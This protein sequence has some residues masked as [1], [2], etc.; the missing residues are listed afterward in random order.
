MVGENSTVLII[1]NDQHTRELYQ[2]FLKRYYR[3]IS[4]ADESEALEAV[5]NQSVST[6]ILEPAS[7]NNQGWTL[8][9]KLRSLPQTNEVP[10]ILCSTQDVRRRGTELGATL[11]ML[12]PVLPNVLHAAIRQVI[13]GTSRAS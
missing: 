12:K 10:I 13:V 6:I 2:R 7:L 1:E 11:F 8:L 3:V 4:C 5:Q 9:E